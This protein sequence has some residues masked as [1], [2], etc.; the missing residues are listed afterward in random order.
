MEYIEGEK[1]IDWAEKSETKS[2]E[3]RSVL[4]NVLRDKDV[5]IC[6]GTGNHQMMTAQFWDWGVNNKGTKAH[7]TS[8]S[9]GD[10]NFS[11]NANIGVAIGNPNKLCISIEG[12][13]SHNMTLNS[14]IS[15]KD[16]NI[17][18]AKIFVLDDNSQEMVRVWQKLFFKGRI[19]STEH[20][21]P[22]YVKIA[23]GMGIKGFYL[24][25]KMN[26]IDLI[27]LSGLENSK[28]EVRRLIS[29]NAIK[30]NNEITKKK[31]IKTIDNFLMILFILFPLY[32][33]I[34]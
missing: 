10:M 20:E 27:I 9:S 12:D 28:S 30:I 24:D 11:L 29:G 3:V 23:E 17:N 31:P 16:Y 1:I 8:G 22:D 26:I 2:Q 33:G 13:G 18:N 19:I 4:N 5:I 34:C 14:L 32:N 15:Y 6:T 7:I 25:N 21:N